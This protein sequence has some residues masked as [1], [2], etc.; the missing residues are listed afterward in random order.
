MADVYLKTNLTDTQPS[1]LTEIS[2]RNTSLHH[3]MVH[4]VDFFLHIEVLW[5]KI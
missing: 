3:K 1:E 5:A 4:L 2:L